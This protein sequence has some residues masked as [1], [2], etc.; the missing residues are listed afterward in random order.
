[1]AATRGS[2]GPS[3]SSGSPGR[4][5]VVLVG[6][7]GAG[8]TTVGSLL[9]AR[10]GVPLRDADADVEAAAGM[11][12]ADI[13]IEHG[14]ERFR[15]LERAAVVAA[16]EG[17]SGVLAVGGGAILDPATRTDLRGHRVVHLDVGVTDATRRVGLARDRP[18]LVEGPRAKIAQMLRARAP[19]YAE[20][21]TAAVDTSGRTPE[22]VTQMI[23]DLL[24]EP[25]ATGAGA[26]TDAGVG[27]AG[28]GDAGVGDAVGQVRR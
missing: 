6:P 14:E 16:L 4:P 11:T 19:L 21:A 1:M 22:E 7:P 23:E 27:D 15:A 20:V 13:F 2:S 18:L 9:A 3:G 17:H 28:V 25:V 5:V 24:A 8:K 26:G 12:V 10:L